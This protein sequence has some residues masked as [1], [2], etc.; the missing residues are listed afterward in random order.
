[1]AEKTADDEMSVHSVTLKFGDDDNSEEEEEEE[2]KKK[3][4]NGVFQREDQETH[5]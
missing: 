1:M 2:E 4:D 5:L 3:D